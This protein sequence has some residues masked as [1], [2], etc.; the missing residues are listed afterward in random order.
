MGIRKMRV[1]ELGISLLP[2]VWCVVRYGS[3][4]D[5]PT[6][7][8]GKGSGMLLS[9]PEFVGMMAGT[10]VLFYIVSMVLA[11]KLA[12]WVVPKYERI[13][14]LALVIAFALMGLSLVGANMR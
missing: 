4:V 1:L 10:G 5:A 3:L 2:L 8:A 11:E 13:L 6:T 9:K 7:K 14:R 12:M